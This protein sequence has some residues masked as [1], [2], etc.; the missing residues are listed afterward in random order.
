MNPRSRNLEDQ[1]GGDRSGA[2]ANLSY[3]NL[4]FRR[5][6]GA[7]PSDVRARPLGMH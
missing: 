7:S 2:S 4:A 6:Y 5:R 1:H 3:F